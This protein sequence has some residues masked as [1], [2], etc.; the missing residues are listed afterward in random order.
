MLVYISLYPFIHYYTIYLCMYMYIIR[1]CSSSIIIAHLFIHISYHIL[2]FL[3]SHQNIYTYFYRRYLACTFNSLQYKF[4]HFQ[5]NVNVILISI[6]TTYLHVHVM[7]I[8][9]IKFE[10]LTNDNTCFAVNIIAPH[11]L[12]ASLQLPTLFKCVPSFKIFTL[13]N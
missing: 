7:C 11:K 9:S 1:T 10:C 5:L 12:V 6:K 3:I 8:L 4:Q 13:G 2:N